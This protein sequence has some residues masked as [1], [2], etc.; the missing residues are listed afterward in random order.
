MRACTTCGSYGHKEA[1][2]PARL[3]QQRKDPFGNR[4]RPKPRAVSD[5]AMRD[6]NEYTL[7]LNPEKGE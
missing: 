5:P 4:R 3:L 1:Y 2:C 6:A 7:F